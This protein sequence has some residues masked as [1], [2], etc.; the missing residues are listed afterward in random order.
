MNSSISDSEVEHSSNAPT[1]T[2]RR[3]R[4]KYSWKTAPNFQDVIFGWA[5][6]ALAIVLFAA[7]GYLIVSRLF[8]R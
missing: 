5:G 8:F 3:R 4:L 6:L 7:T 1:M 2:F